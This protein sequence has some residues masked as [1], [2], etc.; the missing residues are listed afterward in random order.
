LG[1]SGEYTWPNALDIMGWDVEEDGLRAIFSTNIPKLIQ[2]D[3]R[4]IVDRFLARNDLA[5]GDIDL[6]A[7]HPG[8]AKVLTAL[9]DAFGL[10]EGGLGDSRAT[11]D[12]FG[13]MS[14][15][16]VLFVLA[17]MDWRKPFRRVLLSS[18]GPG[19]SAAFQLL[20]ER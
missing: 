16:T 12:E 9:E 3:M 8:G 15:A 11:L 10:D 20:G 5:R 7:S 2:Q 1:A 14:A 17:R 19:F 6:F 13:N 4:A 18:M